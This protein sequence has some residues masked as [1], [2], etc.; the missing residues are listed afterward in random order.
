[1]ATVKQFVFNPFQE[2]SFVISN[3][4]GECI[5]IDP[6]CYDRNEELVI[7][8]YID[9]HSLMPVRL[10]NT[11]CHIDHVFGNRYFYD[12]YGL[13]PEFHRRELDLYNMQS[14]VANSY[15]LQLSELPEVANFLEEGEL[16][17]FGD[18]EFSLLFTPGH[19]PGSLTLYNESESY[20]IAGDVLFRGSIGR[21]DLP[22]G[23]FQTLIHSIKTELLTLPDEVKVYCGHGPTTTI[24]H[25][26]SSNPFLV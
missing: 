23:D 16:I 3:S 26:R 17:R 25:E 21:T 6:G 18:I 12:R 2:N 8:Q 11:H 13:S 20:V 15:G 1:M 5:V 7:S 24:G 10:I 9:S 19:S 4:D 14:A 22:G